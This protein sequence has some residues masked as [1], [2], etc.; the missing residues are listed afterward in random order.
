MTSCI[1]CSQ[2]SIR[3]AV[4]W[5]SPAYSLSMELPRLCA[6]WDTAFNIAIGWWR[7]ASDRFSSLEQTSGGRTSQRR[8]PHLLENAKNDDDGF[9]V[10]MMDS[11]MLLHS[12]IFGFK[13]CTYL[14]T[15]IKASHCLGLTCLKL[16]N[17]TGQPVEHWALDKS[18]I[19]MAN[20]FEIDDA[21]G[22]SRL[23]CVDCGM[24]LLGK[25]ISITSQIQY[26]M[27]N[28]TWQ[29]FMMAS[30]YTIHD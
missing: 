23:L 25:Q 30:S 15:E 12:Y 8:N 7:S 18:G 13:S 3:F 28:W 22:L 6:A 16:K 10:L 1:I 20:I 4:I 27:V 9:A 21:F 11:R 19:A 14:K 17:P 24:W 29:R 5:V 2:C 26:W